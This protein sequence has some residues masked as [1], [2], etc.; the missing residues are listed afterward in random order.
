MNETGND[1]FLGDSYTLEKTTTGT[2]DTTRV[3]D[4][5]TGNYSLSGTE[6]TTSTAIESAN[7]PLTGWDSYTE[8]LTDSAT[9]SEQ[10]NSNFGE[11]TLVENGTQTS[12]FDDEGGGGGGVIAYTISESTTGSYNR[13]TT[14]DE[15]M[16]ETIIE[17]TTN[18][19]YTLSQESITSLEV[20]YV[21]SETG[22]ENGALL[23]VEDTVTGDYSQFT[24]GSD[25][26]TL[27]ESG[28]VNFVSPV[29][30]YSQQVTG[31]ENYGTGEQGNLDQQTS[32]MTSIGSGTYTR[33]SSAEAR[34]ASGSGDYS[35]TLQEMG[36]AAAGQFTQNESGTD[37]YGLVDHFDN[38]S[39]SASGKPGNITYNAN[40]VPFTDPNDEKQLL[41]K[42]LVAVSQHDGKP[43]IWYTEVTYTVPSGMS[44]E[45]RQFVERIENIYQLRMNKIVEE[46]AADYAKRGEKSPVI[47][48][49]D[50]RPL[51]PMEPTSR[52][53]PSWNIGPN[54]CSNSQLWQSDAQVAG[55]MYNTVKAATFD[56]AKRTVQA[57]GDLTLGFNPDYEL[58]NP[59]I[60][61]FMNHELSRGGATFFIVV[62]G[63]VTV[64]SVYAL[65]SAAIATS[66]AR[67]VVAEQATLKSTAEDLAM[68]MK[69]GPFK[70]SNAESGPVLTVLRDRVT[71]EIFDA[72]NMSQIPDKLHPLLQSRLDAYI[73]AKGG[74]LNPVTQ[75]R[76]CLGRILNSLL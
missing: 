29:L 72:Q 44:K 7:S 24:D 40:G 8:I 48:K 45:D 17:A 76:A 38:V 63:G 57:I 61:A 49:K 74:S 23:E 37:R 20:N 18:T 3:D 53:S 59:W 36:N 56:P 66:Q 2:V 75:F 70:Q 27:C 47:I 54:F 34:L 43:M 50:S 42:V 9:E 4:P 71:G 1:G 51:P 73:I 69:K 19:D 12:S 10:G 6:G 64:G 25:S 26:Y 60:K 55:M 52:I 32:T 35:Y 5:A 31:S 16:G 68:A 39:N 22:Q 21:I 58:K 13:T 15:S 41:E 30:L 28:H 67:N 62:D 33:V 14:V 65:Q 11:Y 46:I